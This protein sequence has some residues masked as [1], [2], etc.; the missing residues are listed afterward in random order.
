MAIKSP[1]QTKPTFPRPPSAVSGWTGWL[2]VAAI[3]ICLILTRQFQLPNYIAA[4]LLLIGPAVAML[5]YEILWVRPWRAA[6]SA[7]NMSLPH[8]VPIDWQRV[9]TKALA[10]LFAW[11]LLAA[12]FTWI[13]F[14][15]HGYDWVFKALRWGALP[16][17]LMGLAYL[18]W[19]DRY[20]KQPYDAAWHLGQ[21]LLKQSGLIKSLPIK[22]IAPATSDVSEPLAPSWNEALQFLLGWFIKGFFFVFLVQLLPNQTSFFRSEAFDPWTSMFR[23]IFVLTPL[24][25]TVDIVN[26]LVGYASTFK[27]LNSHIRSPN[28]QLLGWFAALSCYPPFVIIGGY[29]WSD[30]RKGGTYWDLWLQNPA[31]RWS[32]AIAVLICLFTYMWATVAFGIRFSNLTHRGILTHGPYRLF[33]H[34]AYIAKNTYWWLIYVP[35][36]NLISTQQA[37]ICCGWLLLLNFTYYLRAQ[38]EAA[39]LRSDPVY[40]DYEDW[41]AS[42]NLWQRITAK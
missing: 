37:L 40:R 17:S 28:N 42:N 27:V 19:V 25:F 15:K 41:F 38:T 31:L 26:A 16:L 6:D 32:W 2:G 4:P 34:P 10:F 13:P 36:V 39:H 33:K 30:W 1:H 21:L 8:T 22:N 14:Y 18:I 23:L 35:F 24:M 20:L 11:A 29:A 9:G 5:G 7:V 12:W 3:A